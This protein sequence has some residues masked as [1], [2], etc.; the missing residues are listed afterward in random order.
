MMVIFFLTLYLY[1]TANTDYALVIFMALASV[2]L[3]LFT[4]F[5]SHNL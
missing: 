3:L 2:P 5:H 4:Y 1:G